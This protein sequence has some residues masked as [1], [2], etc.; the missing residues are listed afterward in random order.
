MLLFQRLTPMAC[1]TK[2]AA[3][4]ESGQGRLCQKYLVFI[5]KG[6]QLETAGRTLLNRGIVK[7]VDTVKKIQGLAE[8][9]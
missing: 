6:Y 1:W 4:S 9:T 8:R 5:K 3:I 2:L 7:T